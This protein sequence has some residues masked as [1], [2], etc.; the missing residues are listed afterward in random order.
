M[1]KVDSDKLCLSS[2]DES[3]P[4][5]HIMKILFGFGI[6]FGFRGRMEHAKMH[7]SHIQTGVFEKGH[8]FEGKRFV[9]VRTLLDK[10]T[11]SPFITPT[12]GM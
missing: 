4:I 6:Y 9:G 10:K 2:F 5:Q 3:D 1:A 8:Q 11:S 12:Q 7:V